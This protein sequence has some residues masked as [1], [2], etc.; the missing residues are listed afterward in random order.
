MKLLRGKGAA[1]KKETDAEQEETEEALALG[2]V[3]D[4]VEEKLEK[5][6]RKERP[7][8]KRPQREANSGERREQPPKDREKRP[9][10]QGGK[11]SERRERPPKREDAAARPRR[12]RKA[13]RGGTGPR[14]RSAAGMSAPAG[15]PEA[16][17]GRNA[18]PATTSSGN[19]GRPRAR[20]SQQRSML[21]VR[22]PVRCNRRK[23][24]NKTMGGFMHLQSRPD[25][26]RFGADGER[27][28]CGVSGAKRARRTGGN[29]IRRFSQGPV[30][31]GRDS[32]ENGSTLLLIQ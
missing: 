3:L 5:P 8:E 13:G 14:A 15:R 19:T 11:G 17:A 12:T 1:E 30:L 7:V 2:A 28:F 26:Y 16:Q 21:Q 20:R 24:P 32:P 23:H 10:Q 6:E 4:P 22:R 9:P 18:P 25:F 31:P 29:A 27:L